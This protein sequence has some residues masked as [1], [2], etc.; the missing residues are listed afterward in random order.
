M[1]AADIWC[2]PLPPVTGGL[3]R[4]RIGI[5]GISIEASTFS[6]HLSD[7]EAFTVREGDDLLSYYPFLDPGRDLREAAEWV[8]LHHGRALPGG[9]VAPGTYQRMKA[10]ILELADTLG[11]FDG[12]L[13]DLHGA[14]SVVGMTDAEADLTTALREVIGPEPLIS[15]TQDLHGNVSA[16]LVEQVDLIT[17]YRMAPHE[18]WLNTKERA[19]HNLLLRLRAGTGRPWKAFVPIPLLLPGEKTSTRVE[20]AAGIYD[21]VARVADRD[22]VCDAALWVGYAW[23]DEPRCQAAVV[24]T[25]DDPTTVSSG[26]RELAEAW[27]AAR[28]EF[29]FVGPTDTLAGALDTA[30]ADGSPRPHVISDSG[31]NPTA[32]GAGDVSWTVRELLADPRLL[33]PGLTVI[34]ASTFDPTAVARCFDAGIGA[35]VSLRIGGNIDAVAPPAEMTGVV[36]SLTEGDPVAGRQAVVRSG[37]LH[38]VITERRKPFHHL[39]DFQQL[40]LEPGEAD[41]VVVKIGYLEPELFALAA[42]WTLALTPGGVDQDLIRLGHRNLKPGTWPFDTTSPVPDLTPVIS[43]REPTC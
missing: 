32:G 43:R 38:V 41:V 40:G 11:P 18:D 15:C 19:A 30:L 3:S 24:V 14:M 2:P 7:D 6:P 13:L 34:H 37:G 8:P 4:P 9:P 27:W 26:A 10:R 33:D 16:A 22:G 36:F 12:F 42:G 5:A 20:P 1:T 25:G 31:D 29:S 17:C 35:R 28:D 21:R 23:A 39:A